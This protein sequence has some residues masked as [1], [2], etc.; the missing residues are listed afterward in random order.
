MGYIE[1]KNVTKSFN[2]NTVID[3]LELAINEKDVLGILGPSG[4]GK[5]TLLRLLA[6][7][8]K[9]DLG[10]II[11]NKTE[12]FNKLK[13]IFLD[14][15][16]RNIAMVFQDLALWPHMTVREHLSFVLN[17]KNVS[18]PDQEELINDNLDLVSLYNYSDSY[19][20]ELSGGEKQRL[21]IVRA[22]IQKPDVLLFD[23]PLSNL[24]Q[25]LRKDMMR[26]F[27]KLKEEFQITTIYVT[28]NYKDVLDLADEIAVLDKGKIIQKNKT[29]ELFRNPINDFVANIVGRK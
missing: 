14:P 23:E 6:G 9:P 19:P 13:N 16:R 21:A 26:E 8:E 5:T 18:K 27:I 10:K 7:F 17:A 15:E 20:H 4:S 24:D 22:L 12:V 2:S 1:F 29:K 28:H 25:I 3:N 11:I